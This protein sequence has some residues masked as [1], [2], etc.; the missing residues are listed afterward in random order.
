RDPMHGPGPKAET[1]PL[2][3]DLLPEHR[4]AGRA[5]LELRAAGLNQPGLVLLPVEL[6]RERLAR[7]HEQHL[8]DVSV[9]LG[10]D[11]LVAPGLVHAPRLGGPGVEAPEVRGVNGHTRRLY[12]RF[13]ASVGRSSGCCE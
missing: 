11:K 10:E 13:L 4:V 12:D 7:L 8:A 9:R 5:K 6:E 2:A 1:G 3:D